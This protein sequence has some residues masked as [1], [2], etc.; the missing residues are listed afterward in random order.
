MEGFKRK[1]HWENIYQN[2]NIEQVSWYQPIPH[3]SLSFITHLNLP[4]DAAIID[5][6]GG[7]SFLVDHLLHLGYI[8][9]TV[10]DISALAIEKTKHRLG[11]NATKVKWIVSDIVDF[12]P[13]EKYDFWH[14]RAAFHF[15]TKVLDITTYNNI[16]SS[17]ITTNGYL[18]I[19]SFSLDGPTKCSGIEIM[20]YSQ[21]SMFA[22]FKDNFD[23]IGSNITDHKTPFDT[24][25]N[26]IYCC[27]KRK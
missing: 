19:A 25:Q 10:L 18:L 9:V 1:E 20:Q 15:L 13:N 2:K 17:Y 11:V 8:N 14:D 21:E 16:V 5:I 26:F 27:F 12:I 6:G 4:K 22:V 24:I 3:T 23:F 7:D